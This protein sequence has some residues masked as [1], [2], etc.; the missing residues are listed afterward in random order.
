MNAHARIASAL[1]LSLVGLGRRRVGVDAVHRHLA[2]H[3]VASLAALGAHGLRARTEA[4]PIGDLD[5]LRLL[6]RVAVTRNSVG[7]RLLTL[8]LTLAVGRLA[9]GALGVVLLGAGRRRRAG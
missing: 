7:V 1:D 9:L 3:L 8:A 4:R 2:L 5:E 6:L